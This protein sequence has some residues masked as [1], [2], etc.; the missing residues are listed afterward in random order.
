MRELETLPENVK[1]VKNGLHSVETCAFHI[2]RYGTCLYCR[3]GFK[4]VKKKEWEELIP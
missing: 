3:L 4:K 1:V 2:S